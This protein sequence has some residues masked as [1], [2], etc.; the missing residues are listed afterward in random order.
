MSNSTTFTAAEFKAFANN[1]W[2][3]QN[4]A[5]VAGYTHGSP[6]AGWGQRVVNGQVEYVITIDQADDKTSITAALGA[7]TLGPDLSVAVNPQTVIPNGV[8]TKTFNIS[9]PANAV[10]DLTWDGVIVIDKAQVTL[11]ANGD[12]AFT[13]GPYSAGQCTDSNGV[14]VRCE[15]S[16]G[17]ALGVTCFFVCQ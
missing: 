9:G 10:I 6:G 11:D 15:V 7:A 13:V 4:K 1:L 12:G 8:D 2:E 17:S 14:A 5:R 3:A 16:D